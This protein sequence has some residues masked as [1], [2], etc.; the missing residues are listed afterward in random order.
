MPTKL[1]NKIRAFLPQYKVVKKGK[2]GNWVDIF[3]ALRVQTPL[4]T[5]E[6]AAYGLG[7]FLRACNAIHRF[8]LEATAIATIAMRTIAMLT[9]AVNTTV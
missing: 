8:T 4:D 1:A 6:R 3:T 7:F 9:S 2:T 5:I